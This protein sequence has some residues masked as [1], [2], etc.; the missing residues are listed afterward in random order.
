MSASNHAPSP[1]PARRPPRRRLRVDPG[2]RF[3]VRRAVAALT[4][5]ALLALGG[6]LLL[7][8]DEP[9]ARAQAAAG[10]LRAEVALPAPGPLLGSAPQGA[11]GDP[12]EAWA[13]PG[14]RPP[15]VIDGRPVVPGQ[16][17]L[18]RYTRAEGWRM[19]AEQVLDAEG[20]ASD[21]ALGAGEVGR[22]TARGGMTLFGADA[23]RPSGEQR[24]LLTRDAGAS[25]RIVPAPGEEVLLPRAGSLPA[26]Q[27][28]PAVLA[29]RDAGARTES[30]HAIAGRALQTGVARWDGE[31]W[32]R[33][34]ICV[35]DAD[36]VAPAGCTPA[37]TLAG[38]GLEL[39]AV[40]IA[41]GD[42]AA[43]L[44]ARGYRGD[45]GGLALFRRFAD[46]SGTR[47]VVRDLGLPLFAAR[48]TPAAGV[49]EMAP[50][51]TPFAATAAGGGV[52]LD[53][54]F[55]R[56]G[57]E[58]DA[59]LYVD[60]TRAVSWCDP[61]EL[62][63]H[64]LG[65]TVGGR[66]FA[67]PG[68]GFGRRVIAGVVRDGDAATPRYAVLEGDRFATPRSFASPAGGA[69]FGAPDEGWI[70]ATHLTRAA[71]PAAP[72]AEWPLPARQRL[73]ALAAA[74]GGI[75]GAPETPAL[76]VGLS[77]TVL[78]Y[79]PGQGW[80]SEALLGSDGVARPDL[81]GVAWPADDVAYAVGDLGAM[82]R[83]R[84]A[85]GL[86]E[87]DPAAPYDFE[88]N[89]LGIAF[90]P[91]RP[92]RG[93]VVGRAGTLL[94]YGKSWE[95]EEL[96]EAV[97]TSGP[98]RG[99]ADLTSVAFAGPQ[100]LV[101][102][103]SSLLVNDGAGWS[104]DA[105][106]QALIDQQ[107]GSVLAVAGLPDG[108]AVAAGRNLVLLRDGPA[109][110]PWRIS[111]QPLRKA[112]AVA[113]AAFREDGQVRAL[114]SV[115][116]N[117]VG[118]PY[119]PDVLLEQSD[120]EA[121]PPLLPPLTPPGEGALL[122]ET[123]GGWRDEQGMRLQT[124]P[125][126]PRQAEAVL[127][128]LVD[129]AGRGWVA[130]GQEDPLDVQVG[131]PFAM[132]ANQSDRTAALLRYDP[133]GP[134]RSP[135]TGT[136]AT[137][138]PAGVVRL[139]VGGHAS[140]RA[141]CAE[142]ADL[143]LAPDR[144]LQRA[145]AQAGALAAQPGGPRALLYTGGRN[146]AGGAD[147]AEL[148]R[149]AELLGAGAAP[150]FATLAP[151]D[152]D[153]FQAAF[154]AAPA[155][156]GT[157]APPAGIRPLELGAAA[158][159]GRARTHYAFDSDG[160]D[161]TVRVVVIDNSAGSLAASD[162]A[163]NPFEPDGQAAWL[164][165]VLADARTKGVPT[166]VMGVRNLNERDPGAITPEEKATV[167]EDAAQ[168]AALLRDGGASAYLFSAPSSQRVTSIPSGSGEVPAF[169]SGTLGYR[170]GLTRFY[171][172]VPG[173]L[174]L[175]LDA[176]RRDPATNRAP[177]RVR[178]VPVLEDLALEAVDGRVL[179]RS[180]PALFTGL[181]RRPRA[182]VSGASPYVDLPSPRNCAAGGLCTGRIDPEVTFTSSDPDI[183]DFVR[184]DPASDNPRKPFIDPATDKVVADSAS[185]LLCPFNAG[186]TTIT[187]SAG[188]L[189]YSSQLTVRGGSVL[190]PCGTTPL[191]PRRFTRAEPEVPPP[192]APAP[193]PSPA[194]A[195]TPASVPPPPPPTPVAPV[196]TPAPTPVPTPPAPVPTPP[197]PVQ[198]APAPP[199]P[200][201]VPLAPAAPG[202][203]P[204]APPP[205]PPPVGRPIPP[206]GTAPISVGVSV[207]V[208]QPVA[209]VERER[210]REEAIE[211]SQAFVAVAPDPQPGRATLPTV[212]LLAIAAA[213]GAGLRRRRTR[214][215]HAHI[216][217]SGRRAPRLPRERPWR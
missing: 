14:D 175:E 68:D 24:V 8:G 74:P 139:A 141:A 118:Y 122:R 107:G 50:Q 112:I 31:R 125:D 182:G 60:D 67:W 89:L 62:C 120:P 143:Q 206:S 115:F 169:A 130:G 126:A 132:P 135:A 26:E 144:T 156:L 106:A 110:T 193:A 157:G 34:A 71:A 95:Q 161:G 91:G 170:D 70:G 188:G 98:L 136:A 99:P 167:A 116:G 211:Q 20:A 186:T 199:P 149:L 214:E 29:A 202:L 56:A 55:R 76:A 109:G 138:T 81:R 78:R 73:A 37:E 92:D 174:L 209:Q 3:R 176:S 58:R 105:G 13:L 54:R 64:P 42:G 103:G 66:S 168:T 155:P 87:S 142:L 108:G 119:L 11:S 213:S 146:E 191:D 154:A 72:L 51:A 41:A 172:G 59:T 113:A 7:G 101:A 100:A 203:L 114:L 102:A 88:A 75:P 10:A 217:S 153:G 133:A 15:T 183:A 38:S 127:A 163:Q 195:E 184:Q 124:A 84:K 44:L 187:V 47:W 192:P 140:C 165:R 17:V 171:Y 180:T 197:P 9:P 80:D 79:A 32:S 33:E 148:T 111:N 45:G 82:W 205:P 177:V 6:R 61:V 28:D 90:Q 52:W 150:S 16:L 207:P 181:G 121:P 189:T 212:A 128:L 162:P 97:R 158:A 30:F 65:L 83:W 190:R 145:V 40:S 123:A 18:Q 151:G 216:A 35:A 160:P 5:V 104:V 159:T 21:D 137:P 152:A 2:A 12:A 85:T 96:P 69:A 94:R 166:V 178:L 196:P 63:D 93:Y 198:P 204:L 23:G 210:E 48:E 208:T 194:P 22:V 179:T 36:G 134:Q 27:L 57:A 49:T 4:L 215:A 200:P 164:T 129:A 77:G 39:T 53:A 185:G 25:L 117:D 43:W 147:A 1:R 173:L 86:W 201:F 46:A 131:R 19:R